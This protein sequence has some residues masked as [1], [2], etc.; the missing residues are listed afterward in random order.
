MNVVVAYEA[1]AHRGLHFDV[2][3]G[4]IAPLAREIRDDGPLAA[5]ERRLEA[6]LRDDVRVGPVETRL[7]IGVVHLDRFHVVRPAQLDREPFAGPILSRHPERARILVGDSTGGKAVERRRRGRSLTVSVSD[8]SGRRHRGVVPRSLLP[9]HHPS[10]S[11]PTV[12]MWNRSCTPTNS[13]PVRG[14]SAAS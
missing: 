11:S 6:E 4:A 10:S 5:V 12:A 9:S 1:G 7:V 3:V 2:R 14:L 13:G 8:A